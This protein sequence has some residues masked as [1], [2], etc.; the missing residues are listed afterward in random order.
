MA[1]TRILLFLIATGLSSSSFIP[2]AANAAANL[3]FSCDGEK[4][5]C[6]CDINK[7]GD[8]DRMKGKCVGGTLS[9]CV[10]LSCTCTMKNSAGSLQKSQMKKTN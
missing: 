10:G 1:L 9:I 3:G 7:T 8:C 2:L 6:E 5:E 4:S